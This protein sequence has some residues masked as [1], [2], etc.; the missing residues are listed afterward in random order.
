MLKAVIF[1][2]GGALLY[3][4][5]EHLF[6]DENHGLISLYGLPRAIYSVVCRY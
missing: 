4:I 6:L 1:D 3:D 5:W 2:V